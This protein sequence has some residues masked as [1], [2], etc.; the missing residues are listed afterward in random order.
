MVLEVFEVVDTHYLF[1]DVNILCL[2]MS[3]S[4]KA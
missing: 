4:M 1:I 2:G 3:S